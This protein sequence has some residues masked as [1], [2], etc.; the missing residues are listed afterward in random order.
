MKFQI[1]SLK[2]FFEQTDKWMDARTD[3]QSSRNQYAPH[4][5]KVGG[6]KRE[7]KK[8]IFEFGNHI[9]IFEWNVNIRISEYS[10]TSLIKSKL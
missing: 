6:I 10:L 2:F 5:F 9:R 7:T 1:P 8:R 4:F 3:G